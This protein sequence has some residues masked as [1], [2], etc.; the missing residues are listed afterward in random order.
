VAPDAAD[1]R[2]LYLDLM[3]KCLRNTIYEDP[4]FD[5][6]SE[7]RRS[8]STGA[9]WPTVAHTMISQAR[10]GNLRQL[11]RQVLWDNVPGD[12]METGVWRGGACIYLR[13]ILLA[14][15]VTDRRVIVADS[16]DG[17]P[18]PDPDKY[19]A[20]SGNDLHTFGD[21]A[22]SLDEV[23]SNFA[24]YGLLDDQVVFVKGWFRETLPNAPVGRLA[25]LRLDG[26]MYE[27]TMD[28]LT[29]LYEKVSPGGFVI[30]DDYEDQPTAGQAVNDFR[31]TRAISEAMVDIDDGAVYWRKTA[32]G[33]SPTVPA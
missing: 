29:Y 9:D 11:V 10:L 4:A 6:W 22:V 15:G 8:R 23:K 13:A 7:V 24:R 27:S 5:L 30:V 32:G 16:F 3:E 18:S 14:Y 20:D 33:P 12:V 28:A 25:V 31:A 21:L 26:D 1:A 2:V 17:L 19:P